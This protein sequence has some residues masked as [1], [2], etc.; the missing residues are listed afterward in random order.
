[1]YCPAPIPALLFLCSCLL[2]LCRKCDQQLVLSQALS[3]YF[4][5]IHKVLLSG[6]PGSLVLRFSYNAS[7]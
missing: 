3:P 6:C 1:M 5:K 2:L 7:H 4:L